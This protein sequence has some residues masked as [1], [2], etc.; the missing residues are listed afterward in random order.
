MSGE[1]AEPAD[2]RNDQAGEDIKTED[3]SDSP[4]SVVNRKNCHLTPGSS[5]SGGQL[6]GDLPTLHPLQQLV[7]VPGSHLPPTS[8][9]LLSQTQPGHQGTADKIMQSSLSITLQQS[10]TF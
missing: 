9:F 3:I 2:T 6:S 7:L 5:A 1:S 4:Q 10:M 8:Q